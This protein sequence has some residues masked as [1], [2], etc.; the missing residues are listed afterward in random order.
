MYTVLFLYL[1]KIEILKKV[2][3]RGRNPKFNVNH[4]TS[5]TY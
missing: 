2:L 4:V 5:D 1:L 3:D